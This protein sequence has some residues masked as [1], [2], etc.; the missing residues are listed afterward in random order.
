MSETNA[1]DPTNDIVIEL[2]DVNKWY[3]NFQA[4]RD[5]NIKVKR[6]ER[7]VVCGPSGSGK[8]TLIRCINRLE[9]HQR[10][11]I[12]VE[13]IELTEKMALQ[14]RWQNRAL[15]TGRLIDAG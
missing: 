13:G 14:V 2:I 6:G 9:Y 12:L 1:T 5:I 7:V 3:G 10:G 15:F 11:Q 4:L 8:S